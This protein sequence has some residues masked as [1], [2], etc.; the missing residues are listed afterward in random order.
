M[1]LDKLI[2]K[3]N[4][5]YLI[6]QQML[7]QSYLLGR[8]GIKDIK[9]GIHW[10]TLAADQGCSN[11]QCHLGWMYEYGKGVEVDYK[12]AMKW[13]KKASDQGYAVWDSRR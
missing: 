1:E 5:G 2:E 12:K 13:Y 11:S 3:A 8:H 6:E 9:K 10:L 7:G 4:K